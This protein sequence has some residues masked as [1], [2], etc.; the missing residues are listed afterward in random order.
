MKGRVRLRR[1]YETEILFEILHGSYVSENYN[2]EMICD[3]EGMNFITEFFRDENV[4]NEDG[5]LIFRESVSKI[6]ERLKI[7]NIESFLDD[8]TRTYIKVY[9]KNEKFRNYTIANA[10]SSDSN[11]RIVFNTDILEIL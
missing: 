8:F 7:E 5:R 10:Y 9:P 3:K 11:I 6:K 4:S 2:Y 1:V